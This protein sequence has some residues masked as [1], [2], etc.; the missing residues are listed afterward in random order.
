LT[1]ESRGAPPKRASSD[2]PQLDP[3]APLHHVLPGYRLPTLGTT[4]CSTA[5]GSSCRTPLGARFGGAPRD[6]YVNTRAAPAGPPGRVVDARIAHCAPK[7]QRSSFL[8]IYSH[9]TCTR[10]YG[11]FAYRVGLSSFKFSIEDILILS[12]R[13]GSPECHGALC[14]Q[15]ST[16]LSYRRSILKQIAGFGGFRL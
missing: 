6:T 15:L 16:F 13:L 14:V 12:L 3:A 8:G 10:H 7:G 11:Q 4:G 9:K 5:G 2:A 1:E